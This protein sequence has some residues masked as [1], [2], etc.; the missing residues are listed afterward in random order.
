[1]DYPYK[2]ICFDCI[3]RITGDSHIN[4]DSKMIPNKTCPV[5]GHKKGLLILESHLTVPDD[6]IF[7]GV[8]KRVKHG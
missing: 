8:P 6:I 5:C 4:G 2:K 7:K 3:R 1:M